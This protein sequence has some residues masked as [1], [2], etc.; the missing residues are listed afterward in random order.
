MR[1]TLFHE[2][3]QVLCDQAQVGDRTLV[4]ID[5]SSIEH[6]LEVLETT[7]PVEKIQI[8]SNRWM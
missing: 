6:T 3:R 8:H 7:Q 4:A 1:D 5:L 2:T